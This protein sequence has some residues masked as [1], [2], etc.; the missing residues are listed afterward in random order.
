MPSMRKAA[1]TG[2]IVAALTA[3]LLAAGGSAS[4]T[5]RV[6]VATVTP[7]AT[8]TGR[9]TRPAALPAGGTW[10]LGRFGTVVAA[11]GAQRYGD[12][13]ALA[14]V[15]P[16]QALVASPTGHGY[17]I[18]AGDGGVFS[19]GDAHFYGSTGGMRL[20]APIVG[21]A[22]S[23]TGAGY[24]LI[25]A[26]GG[27]FSFGDAHFHGST[28]N[29][30][31][32]APVVGMSATP[33]ANGYWLVATD[34]GVFGFGD[35]HFY[36]SLGGTPVGAPIVALA[37][38]PS[39][40][41]YWL[42]AQ[43]GTVYPFGDAHSFGNGRSD[44]ASATLLPTAAGDGYWIVSTTGDVG[45]FGTA[46][47]FSSGTKGTIVA[48]TTRWASSGSAAAQPAA[49][50]WPNSHEVALTFDDGPSATYTS[51]V[52]ATLAR[53]GVPATFFTVGE[54]AAE[55]TD[56]LRL[57]GANGNSVEDHSWDHADLTHLTPSQIASELSRTADVVQA[58]IGTRPI[59]FRPPYGATNATVRAAGASLGLTQILW[60]VDPSD[61]KQ[62]GVSAIVD[63]VLGAATGKG[64]L[65]GI[66]DG[67]GNRSET[68]A[69]L[70]AI[71]DGLRARGYRFVRLC[72]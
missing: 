8:P 60:N 12:V 2:A 13:H 21:M 45:A 72:A 16:V 11:A 69:A 1:A 47:A 19:F 51:Q 34:G 54:E 42:L 33:S 18:V 52:V 66:H 71:I 65:V 64:L 61:Y 70:P 55:H 27:V 32:R 39:G 15:A 23:R 17:W 41:G 57:E 56:L 4:R 26:D 22:R 20:N 44:R 68:V 38:T 58:A 40:H 7:A 59:C 9:T 37:P 28:G 36:G 24:W 5:P 31:L 67:G 43:N 6:A 10:L 30:H 48:G 29:L 25:G 53:Y 63:N 46:T 35:A 49:L 3:T 50:Y 62:P 14:L